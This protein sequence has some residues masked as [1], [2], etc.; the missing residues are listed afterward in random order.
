MCQTGHGMGAGQMGCHRGTACPTA[1]SLQ[2]A[3]GVFRARV[4]TEGGG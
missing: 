3:E 2:P 4:R 1:L